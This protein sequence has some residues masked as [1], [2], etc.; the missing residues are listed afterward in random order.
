M[1]GEMNFILLLVIKANLHWEY[2]TKS[3]MEKMPK[4]NTV[5]KQFL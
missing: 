5:E 4:A 3:F 1:K 2:Y